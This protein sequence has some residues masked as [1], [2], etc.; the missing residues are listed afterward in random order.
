MGDT[1]P[2]MEAMDKKLDKIGVDIVYLREETVRNEEW[3]KTLNDDLKEVHAAVYGNGNIGL[4]QELQCTDDAV[5]NINDRLSHIE[6]DKKQR[7]TLKTTTKLEWLRGWRA[8]F[9]TGL[10]VLISTAITLGVG[11]YFRAFAP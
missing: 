10:T 9:F 1:D 4:K 8:V 2:F 6:D 11:G 7:D 3:H 5:G